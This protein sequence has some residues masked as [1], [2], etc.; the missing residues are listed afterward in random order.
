[1]RGP[2]QRHTYEHVLMRRFRCDDCGQFISI[3]DFEAGHAV[4]YLATPDSEYTHEEYVTLCWK[5][6]PKLISSICC[7]EAV[8]SREGQVECCG[9]PIEE[10]EERTSRD[11]DRQ[12]ESVDG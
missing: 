10:Y 11:G 1:M 3:G 6:T 8:Y 9:M 5:H 2:V 7:G 12:Q 4:R